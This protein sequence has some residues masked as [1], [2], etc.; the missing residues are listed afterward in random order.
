MP[1]GGQAVTQYREFRQYS[2]IHDCEMVRLSVADERGSEFWML[3]PGAVG[4]SWRE[5]KAEALDNIEAAMAQGCEPGEVRVVE[6]A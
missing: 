4:K 1:C 6:T 3:I 2:A 5:R